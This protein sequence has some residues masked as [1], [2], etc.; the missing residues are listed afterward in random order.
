MDAMDKLK[1]DIERCYDNSTKFTRLRNSFNAMITIVE[2]FKD[3]LSMYQ[4]ADLMIAHSVMEELELN[5]EK[6][7]NI[8]D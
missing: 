1:R 7:Y 8:L 5:Y 6:Y 3:E 4:C 2:Q